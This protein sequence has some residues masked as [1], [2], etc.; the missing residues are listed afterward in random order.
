MGAKITTEIDPH[1]KQVFEG[2]KDKLKL[3]YKDILEEG[4]LAKVKE[5]D[6][7]KVEEIEIMRLE[8]QLSAHK[9]HL[10]TLKVSSLQVKEK[11]ATTQNTNGIEAEREQ[12]FRKKAAIMAKAVDEES[13]NWQHVAKNG[14]FNS[15]KEAK[16]W[17]LNH[18]PEWRQSR[19]D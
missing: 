17:I 5:V 8:F 15:A 2:M 4:I 7:I 10:A 11:A 13:I 9:M 16:E 19:E 18:L 1:I 14:P 3:T 6:P 12:W